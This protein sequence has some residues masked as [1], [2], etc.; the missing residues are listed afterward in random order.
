[1]KRLPGWTIPT[2]ISACR[3]RGAVDAYTQTIGVYPADIHPIVRHKAALRGGQRFPILG[4]A[5]SG[6]GLVGPQD[7]IEPVRRMC[8]WI[9][10]ET[11][12]PELCAHPIWEH[13]EGSFVLVA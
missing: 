1:V 2:G 7:G 12:G 8:K 11:P 10:S 5:F 4:F 6:A 9:V 13:R 3:P